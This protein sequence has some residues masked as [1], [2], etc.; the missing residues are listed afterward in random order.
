M[1]FI[2]VK[3]PKCGKHDVPF[4]FPNNASAYANVVKNAEGEFESTCVV[5]YN[6]FKDVTFPIHADVLAK[7]LRNEHVPVDFVML[8]A[9]ITQQMSIKNKEQEEK[10]EL[11]EGVVK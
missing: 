3:C 7:C 10:N 5:N 4:P 9:H 1:T 2:R 6:D 11:T 8:F